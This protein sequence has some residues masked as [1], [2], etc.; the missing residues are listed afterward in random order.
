LCELVLEPG[1]YQRLERK[2]HGQLH[3]R[4]GMV[5]AIRDLHDPLC[6]YFKLK[7]AART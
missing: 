3:E 1:P 6:V 7:E 5:T 2:R 4:Q